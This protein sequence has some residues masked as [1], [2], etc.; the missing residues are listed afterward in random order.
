MLTIAT[1]LNARKTP[2]MLSWGRPLGLLVLL[3]SLH[4]SAADKAPETMNL[5]MNTALLERN[6]STC[7]DSVKKEKQKNIDELKVQPVNRVTVWL[8]GEFMTKYVE[9]SN[10]PTCSI[11]LLDN[12]VLLLEA[13]LEQVDQPIDVKRELAEAKLMRA[14]FRAPEERG[15]SYR[16]ADTL[17]RTYLQ[18][19]PINPNEE[20][21]TPHY[22]AAHAYLEAA[23]IT[24]DDAKIDLLDKAIAIGNQGRAANVSRKMKEQLS[25]PIGVAL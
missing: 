10:G 2:G 3:L 22:F 14:A 5:S 19:E 9:F 1:V 8:T 13:Y 7:P 21:A 23:K 6:I 20:I 11:G 4:A 17:I 18:E 15:G 24:Q 25:E 16:E 12:A